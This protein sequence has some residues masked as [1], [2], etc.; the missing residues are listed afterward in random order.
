MRAVRLG[1]AANRNTT[2]GRFQARTEASTA[3]IG[4]VDR[5]RAAD[6]RHLRLRRRSRTSATA[7]AGRARRAGKRGT[8]RRSRPEEYASLVASVRRYRLLALGPPLV[9]AAVLIPLAIVYGLQFG[10]PPLRARLRIRGLRH[11]EVRERATEDM[12]ESTRSWKLRARV[13]LASRAPGRR[14]RSR[15]AASEARP[16]MLV[17]FDV[18]VRAD[19]AALAVDSAVE[20]RPAAP[21]REPRR[22]DDPPDDGVVGAEVVVLEDVDESLRAP[23]RSPHRWPS[24]SSAFAS[25]APGRWQRL[26][27]LVGER[28]PGLLVL[29]ADTRRMRGRYYRKAARKM[30]EEAP[31][32]VWIPSE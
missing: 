16:V 22:A 9:L 29:G 32:L 25:S 24:P 5:G 3:T 20:S 30:R 21:A 26:L 23:A 14:R 12:R 31:C 1:R 27:E 17:T 4:G 8:R 28:S 19:A 13:R 15:G 2:P 6:H 7:S 18:P 11:P 10:L